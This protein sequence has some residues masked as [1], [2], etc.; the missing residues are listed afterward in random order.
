MASAVTDAELALELDPKVIWMIEVEVK[1][2]CDA[3][4]VEVADK[5]EALTAGT[6]EALPDEA[7]SIRTAVEWLE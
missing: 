4:S 7:G 2:V 3:L 6:T 5:S 1:V